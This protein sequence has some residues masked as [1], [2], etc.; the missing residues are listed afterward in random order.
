M[1]AVDLLRGIRNYPHF[2]REPHSRLRLPC[3]DGEGQSCLLHSAE[4]S[5]TVAHGSTALLGVLDGILRI[6]LHSRYYPGVGGIPHAYFYKA[7]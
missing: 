2:R 5:I 7:A 1:C 3:A 6:I 4:R